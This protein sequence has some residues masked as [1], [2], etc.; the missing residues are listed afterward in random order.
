MA[1]FDV[2]LAILPSMD[3]ASIFANG[4]A[5]A[6]VAAILLGIREIIKT[7]S[8]KKLTDATAG[9]TW[10]ASTLQLVNEVRDDAKE[11]IK[12]AREEAL[13][14]ITEARREVREASQEASE[15]R[16]EASSARREAAESRRVAEDALFVVRKIVNAVQHPN[17]TIEIVRELVL[18]HAEDILKE[19]AK[20]LGRLE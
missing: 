6:I 19:H 5:G 10:T 7:L 4:G 8:N 16:R 9:A 12:A 14:Q 17:A 3:W 1:A 18:H 2:A 11:Q 15:A 20:G 13:N